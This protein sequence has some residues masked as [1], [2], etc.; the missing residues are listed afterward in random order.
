MPWEDEIEN[1]LK[2]N[3]SQEFYDKIFYDNG[4]ALIRSLAGKKEGL[5]N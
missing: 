4:M 5:I 3:L 2:M 1:L